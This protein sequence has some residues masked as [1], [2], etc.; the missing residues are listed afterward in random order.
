M[1]T[2]VQSSA[3]VLA[4]G[5][6]PSGKMITTL[7]PSFSAYTLP[8]SVLSHF[9]APARAVP[10]LPPIN[11]ASSLINL[12]AAGKASSSPILSH[13]STVGAILSS[14]SGMKSYLRCVEQC[15]QEVSISP[16]Q[17]HLPYTF[18]LIARIVASVIECIRIC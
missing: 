17:Q 3:Q 2:K 15:C 14:T 11:R 18:N 10:E 4:R 1:L 12:I 7:L 8:C 5:T 13:T 16:T 9:K 6:H